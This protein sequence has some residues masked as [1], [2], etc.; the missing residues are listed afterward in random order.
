MPVNNLD[1]KII[2]EFL[3]TVLHIIP[4]NR[5]ITVITESVHWNYTSWLNIAFTLMAIVLIYRFIKSGGVTMLKMM[6]KQTMD[7]GTLNK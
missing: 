4:T 2:V 3:F 6:D 5:H 1:C 7:M